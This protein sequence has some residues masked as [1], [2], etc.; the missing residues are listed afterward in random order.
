MGPVAV[1]QL[2][3]ICVPRCPAL[4]RVSWEGVWLQPALHL[5]DQRGE[6]LPVL[7]VK[8]PWG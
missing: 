7:S 1:P 6:P 3:L 8:P 4:E 2:T 5:Q